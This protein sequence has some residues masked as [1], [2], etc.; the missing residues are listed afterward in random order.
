MAISITGLS[1][2]DLED[3]LRLQRAEVPLWR[4][5]FVLSAK[6]FQKEVRNPLCCFNFAIKQCRTGLPR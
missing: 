1:D 6:R 3:I 5:R 4:Q 2:V